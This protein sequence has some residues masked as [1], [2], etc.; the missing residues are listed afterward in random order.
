MPAVM[1]QVSKQSPVVYYGTL[2]SRR[3]IPLRKH[4]HSN[5]LKILPP[6]K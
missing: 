5:I 4:A 3:F 2:Q 1:N 6:K